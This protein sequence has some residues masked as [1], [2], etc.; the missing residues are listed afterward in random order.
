MGGGTFV[1]QTATVDG[2]Y[3]SARDASGNLFLSAN[4]DVDGDNL[5]DGSRIYLYDQASGGVTEVANLGGFSGGLALAS[6]G[7]LYYSAYEDNKIA[8]F[9]AA[10]VGAVLAGGASLTLSDAASEIVLAGPGFLAFDSADQ[11]YASHLDASWATHLVA[12]DADG[13]T[14]S[15][16][17]GGGKL[18]V[19]GDTL[20]TIDTDWNAYA[21]DIYAVKAIPEPGTITLVLMSGAGLLVFR[22]RRKHYLRV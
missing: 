4:D 22:K 16:A 6:N 2:V 9:S 1:G 3:D 18:V 15:I 8:S 5:A 11:L 12:L 14:T 7:D 17:D 19:D 13:S 10:Q 20:Y 21:S